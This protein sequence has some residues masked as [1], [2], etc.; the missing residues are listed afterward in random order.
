MS[1]LG[2]GISFCGCFTYQVEIVL[3][4]AVVL[5]VT[6]YILRAHGNRASHGKER[7]KLWFHT[8]TRKGAYALK[9]SRL[10]FLEVLED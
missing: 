9:G 5:D 8:R 7:R 4:I 10:L 6:P 3:L 1:E 2:F